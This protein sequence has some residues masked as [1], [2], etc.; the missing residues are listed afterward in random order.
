MTS[1][2]ARFAKQ[3]TARANAVM[4]TMFCHS[5]HHYVPADRIARTKH[6]AACKACMDRITAMRKIAQTRSK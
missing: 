2:A 3:V 5:G 6:P 1:T 4:G